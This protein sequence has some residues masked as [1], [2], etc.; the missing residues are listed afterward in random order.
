[1]S[2]IKLYLFG[3]P[4]LE[5]NGQP[6]QVSLR[7]ALALFAYLALTRQPHSRDQ[8]A[9][10]FWP[11][12]SQKNA[13]ASLRR[14]LYDIN[15][16]I[17][18]DLLAVTPE[19]IGLNPDLDLWIDV[20]E[21]RNCAATVSL[22]MQTD[23]D[24]SLETEQTLVAAAALYGGDF[25]AGFT[26]PDCPDFD[27]WQFFQREEL[28][29]VVAQVL[30]Q[31]V[32]MYADREAY[33]E[34][35]PHARRW[36][37]LDPLHE[38]AHGR[39]ME[40]YALAGQQA[41]ALRQ[42]EECV[43]VLD[44]E[45]AVP[46][47]DE[48]N[49]LF[50]AI[51]TRKF[52][53]TDGSLFLKR[54]FDSNHR[55]VPNE[56]PVTTNDFQPKRNLPSPLT[57][58][59]GRQQ[60]LIDIVDRLGDPTC[61][62]LTLI[63]TGGIGK[64]RLAIE[65]ARLIADDQEKMELF[66]DG[67]YFVPL[68]PLIAAD[69]IVPAIAQA[70][71]FQFHQNRSP[72]Q[73]LFDYL[74]D[75]Q[76]LLVLDNFEHLLDGA[77]LVAEILMQ[78]HSVKLLV[79]SRVALKLLEEWFFP[80]VGMSMPPKS[81]NGQ[82]VQGQ[83]SPSGTPAIDAHTEQNIEADKL[84]ETYDS[85]QLFCQN[86]A[87]M[88]SDFQLSKEQ[89]SVTRICHLV[90]GM[91][92]GLELAASWLRALSCKQIAD[93]LEKGV[94]ILTTRHQN[95]PE[96]HRSMRVVL[97]Q[98]WQLLTDEEKAVL[99]CLSVFHGD[100]DRKAAT[101]VA[102]AS[103][104]SLA[105]LVEKSLIR[106]TTPGRHQ[107][108]E[109]LRQFASEQ[110]LAAEHE[111]TLAR[112]GHYYLH[113]LVDQG[114]LLKGIEQQRAL[115]LIQ[116]EIENAIPA[117]QYLWHQPVNEKRVLQLRAAADCL[118]LFYLY[119][120]R[121]YEGE[122]TFRRAVKE[123]QAV[124]HA[125]SE[126]EDVESTTEWAKPII[127]NLLAWQSRFGLSSSGAEEALYIAQ[128]SLDV[129]QGVNLTNRDIQRVHAFSLF[130]LGHAQYL[131]GLTEQATH[132]LKASISLSQAAG[133]E[134]GEAMVCETFGRLVTAKDNELARKLMQKSLTLYQ[135]QNNPIGLAE[136]QVSLAAVSRYAGAIDEAWRMYDQALRLFQQQ[137]NS[138]G[139]REALTEK[140]YLA[141]SLGR[142]HDAIECLG[143]SAAISQEVGQWNQQGGVITNLGAAYWL[144]GNFT[145][146]C[147]F[148]QQ[149][150]AAYEEMG[151]TRWAYWARASAA[152]ADA[153]AGHYEKARQNAQQILLETN[154]P[155][156][157]LG[158]ATALRVLGWVALAKSQYHEALHFLRESI[159][160][161][162]QAAD[163]SSAGWITLSRAPYGRALYGAGLHQEAKE[164]LYRGLEHSIKMRS[165]LPA[166]N[167]IA[168][169]SL[170][171]ASENRQESRS[172][173]LELHALVQRY[174]LMT[175]SPLMKDVNQVHIPQHGEPTEQDVVAQ[176][177]G[178]Q[179]LETEWWRQ[180]EMLFEE[181]NELGWG[182][183]A[184]CNRVILE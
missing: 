83:Y 155:D 137:K 3:T 86:A 144:S 89:T 90:E 165:H 145:K 152:E 104:L 100:F 184:D 97:E 175:N 91:P 129:I 78:S 106:M 101:A 116:E 14:F 147:H 30:I 135:K 62:L 128:R 60:E 164:Q 84:F 109:L 31:L 111:A 163:V 142:Y 170:V 140:G 181:L 134:L 77:A 110:L 149:G 156:R 107:L 148:L 28:H 112:Y 27:E 92:L 21:F 50:E 117:W 153:Y 93:E 132:H 17:P 12:S 182:Q 10:L 18:F 25:M 72:Q 85:V 136:T 35:L 183:S 1:M 2:Q 108:H 69:D 70:I 56:Q 68:Q 95:V 178:N 103:V 138:W 73:Q 74:H 52:P 33:D 64:T 8:L 115:M 180:S 87:R 29:Q 125:D 19:A 49:S 16:R 160:A 124:L 40:L 150:I 45:F 179:V 58:F 39:L 63:G 167:L 141:L 94:D 162:A 20:E 88:Q 146:G 174:P 168:T 44:E 126:S 23:R 143:A 158:R 71:G 6:V 166:L 127:A 122:V 96:R 67:V 22:A 139:I 55:S 120:A 171:F 79:T 13:R 118:G 51:R 119:Q 176:I 5:V 113:L 130:V 38:A 4:R 41:A 54:S 42:Y 59:V 32:D 53:A 57:P 82:S 76:M 98:S 102:D 7:K 154:Q 46:P 151:A 159:D 24:L 114:E 9:T 37:A 11:E 105:A 34:A 177:E 15:Q 26:L 133:D 36:L 65:A 172:R 131:L 61:R 47:N 75:K 80:I 123:S 157:I 169:I 43:R 66:A 81:M 48:I 99:S 173:G 161:F 121:Y